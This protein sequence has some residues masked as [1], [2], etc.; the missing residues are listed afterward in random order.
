MLRQITCPKCG[1]TFVVPPPKRKWSELLKLMFKYRYELPATL[2]E[3][4]DNH[5]KELSEIGIDTKHKLRMNFRDQLSA[6][7]YVFVEKSVNGRSMPKYYALNRKSMHSLQG[8]GVIEKKD[9]VMYAN[10]VAD[11]ARAWYESH[12]DMLEPHSPIV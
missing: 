11:I 8:L 5:F 7:L 6:L 3:F 2:H 9:M 1:Y 12:E 4:W 10:E